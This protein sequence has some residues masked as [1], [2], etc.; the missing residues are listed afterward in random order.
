MV[1][2]CLLKISGFIVIKY[3]LYSD[4]FLCLAFLP[5]L[6]PIDRTLIDT[7]RHRGLKTIQKRS[8]NVLLPD[9]FMVKLYYKKYI[10]KR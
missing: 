9:F 3:S 6:T 1:V 8:Q 2:L 7:R 5:Q 10:L 4:P